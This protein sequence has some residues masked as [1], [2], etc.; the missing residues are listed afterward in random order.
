MEV[1]YVTRSD[2]RKKHT[3]EFQNNLREKFENVYIVREGGTNLLALKGAAEIPSLIQTEDDCICTACGTA[4]T[5]SGLI[6]RLEGK[7]NLLGFS[8]L[9]GVTF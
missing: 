5:L 7:K 8:V 9:K 1:H 4:G 6:A 2:Y 3:E